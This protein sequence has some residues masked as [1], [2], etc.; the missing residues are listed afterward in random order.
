MSAPWASGWIRY[1][2]V[3]DQWHAVVVGDAR[4]TRDVQDVDLRVGD[5]LR[6]ERLGV[7]PDG[8]AP[9][10][11]VVGVRHEADL[12]AEL[13]QR[14]VQ[15]VV[16]AA[17]QPRRGHHVVAGAGD[18]EDREGRGS[19][20][21]RQEQRGHATLESGDALLDHIGGRVHDA[22]VDVARLGQPE[23][24]GGVVG[25]AERVRRRLVDRQRPGI[26]GA[27]GALTC[28]DLLRLEAPARGGVDG[29]SGHVR[30]VSCEFLGT[31]K[32]CANSHESQ[33][34][35]H[36]KPPLTQSSGSVVRTRAC[37]AADVRLLNLVVSRG[38]P[39]RMEGC[40]PASR[41]LTLALMTGLEG[42]S[43]GWATA[44][45]CRP[46]GG[47]RRVVV[48]LLRAACRYRSRS[49]HDRP[50]HRKLGPPVTVVS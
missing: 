24:R 50:D 11:E 25:V 31:T 4:D 8:G 2:V 29:L 44:S 30:G 17:V 49:V 1:G 45:W 7:R 23:Q 21:G 12:D 6:E 40:R 43:R 36:R 33:T 10:V 27:V 26:G 46:M 47:T 48:G 20:P 37:L 35:T 38:T 3:D 5:G 13:G 19:L 9:R 18:V 42:N 34:A 41:G 28:V 15:Q 39:P 22:G 32:G 14:V 16:G